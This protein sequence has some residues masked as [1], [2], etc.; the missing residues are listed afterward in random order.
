M[1]I[2]KTL[3]SL[4]DRGFSARFFETSAQALDYLAGAI[5]DCTVGFGGSVTLEQ[6]GVYERLSAGNRVIWHWK[7][8]GPDARIQAMTTDVFLT[9]ANGLSETGEIVNIDGSGN[10]VSSCLYGHKRVY[11]V[12]G[13]NKLAPD[14]DSAIHRARNIAAPKNAQRLGRETPCAFKADK[15]YDCRSA[16]RICKGLVVHMG[17]MTGTETEVVIINEELGF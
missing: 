12:C 10:R 15:C 4:R 7:D 8:G 1:D 11:F 13:I 14:L 3:G 17:P 9:S 16:Q 5:S 2:E 6:M